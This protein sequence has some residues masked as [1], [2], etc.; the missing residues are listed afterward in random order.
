MGVTENMKTVAKKA[1]IKIIK[2][3]VMGAAYSKTI[4]VKKRSNLAQL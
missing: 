4:R 1:V 3:Q 2:I